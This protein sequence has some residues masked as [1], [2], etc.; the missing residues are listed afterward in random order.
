VSF[1][2]RC[3]CFYL[4]GR[5]VTDCRAAANPAL[6]AFYAFQNLR[7]SGNSKPVDVI[8]GGSPEP[9][10]RSVSL[11]GGAGRRQS[12]FIVM[13]NDSDD[14]DD[15]K[16]PSY[17]YR[18]NPTHG[19]PDATPDLGV[20]LRS[21]LDQTGIDVNAEMNTSFPGD[22]TW[23]PL[24]GW[25]GIV[26]FPINSVFGF[27]DAV[28]RLLG[29]DNRTGVAYKIY[30]VDRERKAGAP[31]WSEALSTVVNCAGVGD[32]S[33]DKKGL[34]WLRET[35]W[36]ECPYNHGDKDEDAWPYY[37][38]VFITNASSEVNE[39]PPNTGA[40]EPEGNNHLLLR[41]EWAD[42]PDLNRA[43]VAY[44]RIPE[45]K[46]KLWFTNYYG[47][48]VQRAIRLLAPGR[49]KN[50]PGRPAIPDAFI[51]IQRPE[52][53]RK[54]IGSY[55]GLCFAD[56]S[57]LFERWKKN[58]AGDVEARTVTLSATTHVGPKGKVFGLASD[59][60]HIFVPGYDPRSY[61]GEKYP[62]YLLHNEISSAVVKK[63]IVNIIENAI[64]SG[65]PP[66]ETGQESTAE[67]IANLAGIEIYVG[68]K[69]LLECDD[70]NL[71]APDTVL[72]LSGSD[73]KR[74]QS[75]TELM[76]CLKKTEA[77][78]KDKHLGFME[79]PIF[80]ALRPVFG[81][82]LLHRDK[83]SPEEGIEWDP[84][85][86]TLDGF[87]DLV[88]SITKPKA[89]KG[90][91]KKKFILV[92]QTSAEEVSMEAKPTFVIRHDTNESQWWAMRKYI[93]M[94]QI[95]VQ[96][97]K[98]WPPESQKRPIWGHRDVYAT[99]KMYLYP[100]KKES[101]WPR[102]PRHKDFQ[103]E[104]AEG[105]LGFKTIQPS[106]K[107]ETVPREVPRKLKAPKPPPKTT[108]PATAP[109]KTP[110]E[111]SGGRGPVT[112]KGRGPV[113]SR[114]KELPTPP[115][116]DSPTKARPT[117]NSS[118]KPAG[119]PPKKGA[120]RETSH[121]TAERRAEIDE[122]VAND[123]QTGRPKGASSGQFDDSFDDQVFDDPEDGLDQEDQEMGGQDDNEAAVQ[124][125]HGKDVFGDAEELP[126]APPVRPVK[127]TPMEKAIR[128]RER[129]YAHPLSVHDSQNIPVN[130]PP[131]EKILSV[132]GS[133]MPKVSIGVY[134]PSDVRQ[135][136]KEHYE[137][138]NV[139]ILRTKTCPYDEC[140]F[141]YSSNKPEA[142]QQHLRD[143]HISIGCNFCDDPLFAWW[144]PED[145]Y[146]HFV[147]KHASYFSDVQTSKKDRDTKPDV[148]PE[149]RV[150]A[151]RES[152]W[153][154]CSRCG[155]DHSVLNADFDRNQH[156]SVCYPEIPKLGS[157]ARWTA[158]EDCGDKLPP[159]D[160]HDHEQETDDLSKDGPFCSNCALPLGIFSRP[161]QHKHRAFCKPYGHEE[162]KFCPWDGKTMS[163]NLTNAK[164]HINTCYKKPSTD[165]LG[166]ID[167]WESYEAEMDL[168]DGWSGEED[169][170][171]YEQ[172]EGAQESEENQ[173]HEE[174]QESEVIE[175]SP[176]PPPPPPRSTKRN[177]KAVPPPTKRKGK[178]VTRD[179]D[180]SPPPPKRPKKNPVV[181]TKE[182][183]AKAATKKTGSKATK[184]TGAKKS[185]KVNPTAPPKKTPTETAGVQTRSR[186]RQSANVKKA[187]SVAA[188]SR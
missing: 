161:Y 90:N 63:R 69:F 64:A 37:K 96:A 21:V 132:R 109:R 79:F 155:R 177:D 178:A 2:S 86:T 112:P 116:T 44:L 119:G 113:T 34:E 32:F 115:A 72:S 51:D 131:L 107:Q 106:E 29:L 65:F 185:T 144:T 165:A 110:P 104:D 188:A 43:D 70:P 105:G 129:S 1:S 22:G 102:F 8:S 13:G 48:M 39:K 54:K 154:F 3:N 151:S 123:A 114:D 4:W 62:H 78:L 153:K 122:L 53:D 5:L 19:L 57:E 143:V 127:L 163:D 170:R 152:A 76:M 42:A 25:Q 145:R 82:Y 18:F 136:Q 156:D 60:F 128:L 133:S 6:E 174:S 183:G 147:Q 71:A 100:G 56:W 74:K 49:I 36:A 7:T 166:P 182:T 95:I 149:S 80:L 148:I 187:V 93:V 55:G 92:R 16:D 10:A 168:D 31:G 142:M 35:I 12:N 140:T 176:S 67:A 47:I 83:G 172:S 101:E 124:A 103:W 59:R 162:F 85:S 181:E 17:E 9:R 160:K 184:P 169:F 158:C 94:P 73:N 11:R 91:F 99:K 89:S 77:A 52:Q 138:R 179:D 120:A 139:N 164:A 41:L 26:W 97:V 40:I 135:L 159:G 14:G 111:M 157:F 134:T 58:S 46:P 175:V 180:E 118:T 27:V 130:A 167:L 173:E 68:E 98:E 30:L 20:T 137:I 84:S 125:E 186:A 66:T 88:R 28:D 141:L 81:K 50:R 146:R 121:L 108:K 15:P 24:Y 75:I 87:R 38:A 23:I 150:D 61:D 126:D 45:K 33:S 117:K 171:T